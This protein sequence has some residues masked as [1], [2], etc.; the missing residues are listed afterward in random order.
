MITY[1]IKS[2][3]KDSCR[4][5]GEVGGPVTNKTVERITQIMVPF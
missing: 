4:L 2:M 3:F 5:Y 1:Q